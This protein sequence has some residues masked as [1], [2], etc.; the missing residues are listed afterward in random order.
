L[1]ELENA[2][3][4]AL[5]KGDASNPEFRQRVYRAAATALERTLASRTESD[6]ESLAS[7]KQKLAEAIRST[8]ALYKPAAVPPTTR[9]EL[10]PDMPEIEP[11]AR[12]GSARGR[13]PEPQFETLHAE[14]RVDRAP[15]EAL[16]PK[17]EI[18]DRR[19]AGRPVSAKASAKPAARRAPFAI[20]LSLVVGLGLVVIG[21]WWIVSTGVLQTASERD[22]SVP[23]P[24]L[25]L[26]DESFETMRDP[27]TSSAPALISSGDSADSG[28][29]TLFQPSN[30]TTISLSGGASA[31]V[32]GDSF[33]QFARV[34]TPGAE[35][36]ISIDIPSGT[37]E[38]LSG[39][40]AQFSIIARSDDNAPTQMS[41]SCDFAELGDCGRWRF[42][43]TQTDNEFLFRVE[44]PSASR[45]TKAGSLRINT[46]IES[47]V[48]VVKLSGVRVRELGS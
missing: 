12:P 44:L 45:V 19:G 46:D 9:P 26:D 30:P 43:V 22:T 27:G 20:M 24:P 37:L 38:S 42:S 5:A 15:P 18:E 39:R 36:E 32:D 11:E 21:G 29:V 17:V 14:P 31:D 1:S 33:G 40:T 25:Q 10:K 4:N 13:E 6:T 41:V 16:S 28:W 35:S 48:R 47:G 34:L 2:L 8:E 7:Q 23:N 3:R